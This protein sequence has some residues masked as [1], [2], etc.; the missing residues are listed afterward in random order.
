MLDKAVISN[1]HTF[2]IKQQRSERFLTV[3]LLYNSANMEQ[4]GDRDYISKSVLS[5]LNAGV[6]HENQPTSIPHH[7]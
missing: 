2:D 6:T 7:S 3:I 4:V 5:P 1:T